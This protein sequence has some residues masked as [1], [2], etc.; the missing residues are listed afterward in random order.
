M[1]VGMFTKRY[2]VLANRLHSR[3]IICY[4][5][6]EVETI[7]QWDTGATITSVSETIVSQ[8]GMSSLGPSSIR[9][10][11]TADE[12]YITETYRVAIRLSCGAE[13][14]DMLVTSS[15]IQH[16]GIGVL[17]GMD[18][19]TSGDFSVTNFNGKT[20]FS[21]RTPSKE[22]VDYVETQTLEDANH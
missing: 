22:E 6:K 17:I 12:G 13:Y 3:V 9:T 2:P 8:L 20:T 21:F 11:S 15:N 5:G 10:P 1:K 4:E 19:I 7:A 14:P 18:I 16:Q